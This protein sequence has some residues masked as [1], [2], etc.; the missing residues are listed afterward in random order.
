MEKKMN[1]YR[2]CSE[3]SKGKRT[4]I[5]PRQWWNGNI[6]MVNWILEK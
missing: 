5:K 4:L 6:K 1:E 2:V 3:K